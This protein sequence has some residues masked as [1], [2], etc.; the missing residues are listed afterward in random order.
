MKSILQ[1][2]TPHALAWLT[3]LLFVVRPA[4][5]YAQE[6][7]IDVT[8]SGPED[9]TSIAVGPDG[10]VFVGEGNYTAYARGIFQS[11]DK[12]ATWISRGLSS[13]KICGVAVS[14][15]GVIYAAEHNPAMV[16][17]SSDGGESW[18][19]FSVP[20]SWSDALWGIDVH[21]SDEVFVATNSGVYRSSDMG[22]SW[23]RT[24]AGIKD[25]VLREVRVARTGDIYARSYGGELYRSTNR[26][27]SWMEITPP[28]PARSFAV[29]PPSIIMASTLGWSSGVNY[30][31]TDS[32][33]SWNAV[34]STTIT[35]RFDQ[36]VTVDDRTIVAVVNRGIIYRYD[37]VQWQVA[38]TPPLG[39]NALAIDSAGT[40]Y[41]AGDGG[42]SMSDD[43]GETW[44]AAR[45]MH[46]VFPLAMTT[47]PSGD[48]IA[49]TNTSLLIRSS[50]HG[51][52]WNTLP[53]SPLY[54]SSNG[55]VVN[56]IGQLLTGS[57]GLIIRSSDL[58]YSWDSVYSLGPSGT[59]RSLAVGDS[60]LV[61]AS[62][63]AG[64]FRS[65]DDGTTWIPTTVPPSSGLLVTRLNT[66]LMGN[67]SDGWVQRS[68]DEG[69]T[70]TPVRAGTAYQGLPSIVQTS[71]ADIYLGGN[72]GKI[73]RSTDDG[74]SWS[75][76]DTSGLPSSSV[77]RLFAVSDRILV[78][79]VPGNGTYRS[80]DAGSHWEEWGSGIPLPTSVWSFTMDSAGYV[81]A[82]SEGIART[83]NLATSVTPGMTEPRSF[84]LLQ[85]YPNPFN[86]STAINYQLAAGSR[87]SLRV[88][89]ILGEEVEM[90]VNG[91]QQPGEHSVRFNAAGLPS[92]VYFY[93]IQAGRFTSTKKMLLLR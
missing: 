32:G 39:T 18:T 90:L 79:S 35:T 34:D 68:T 74:Q 47:T 64:T 58:G 81:Y 28:H 37:G 13:S 40:L 15:T 80:T 65:T 5:S 82:G 11:T 57:N 42:M 17:R 36:M 53:Y 72:D 67:D 44:T 19:P 86:P 22:A 92:G 93:R 9:C 61:V 4:A 70:W 54:T 14:A 24:S 21:G 6:H 77:S 63:T 59:C 91:Y 8:P 31:S 73:Y 1:I 76:R 29:L 49:A 52:T 12:G 71:S 75:R 38:A 27:G 2:L 45:D 48:V 55:L 83:I 41:S 62:T 89:N 66:V 46:H 88:Y 69:E 30:R 10:I 25:T 26:G 78:A 20:L 56:R 50:D 33:Q 43:L 85:N 87:V 3:T 84:S 23:E 60:G 16:H 51:T 7:W